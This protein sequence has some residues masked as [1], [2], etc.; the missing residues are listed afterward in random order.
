MKKTKIICTM[1]PNT[2]DKNIMMELAR[3]G[4]DVARFNFSHGDYN[5]PQGRL[6]LMASSRGSDLEVFMECKD[7][8]LKEVK[9]KRKCLK[10]DTPGILSGKMFYAREA[11]A[12][13]LIDE[14]GTL[15]RA[16]EVAKELE[17][18]NLINKYIN[19]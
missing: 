3:N 2:S 4:M 17:E 5:E 15:G 7:E 8:F 1:G 19:S 9:E 12:V 18:M 11:V 10:L 13:G 16:V 6:E 14:I